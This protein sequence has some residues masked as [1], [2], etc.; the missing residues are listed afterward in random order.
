MKILMKILQ[1]GHEAVLQIEQNDKKKTHAGCFIVSYM[2]SFN[3]ASVMTNLVILSY[4]LNWQF[5]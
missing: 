5:E 4:F 3:K 1:N 2:F